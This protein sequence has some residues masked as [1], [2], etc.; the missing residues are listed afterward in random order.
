MESLN[1]D[2]KRFIQNFKLIG[3]D[4]NTMGMEF[5]KCRIVL[6]KVSFKTENGDEIIS[7][8]VKWTCLLRHDILTCRGV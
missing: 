2:K 4:L 3:V 7:S 6:F 8:A 1:K 5:W